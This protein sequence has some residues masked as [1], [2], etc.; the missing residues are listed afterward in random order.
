M[1]RRV[2]SLPVRMTRH[3]A[4]R[5]LLDLTQRLGEKQS[6]EDSLGAVTDAALLLVL[7][8]HS[9]VRLLDT[10]RD[11]FLSSARS[12]VGKEHA[13]VELR[14]GEGVIGWVLDH[15]EGLA[16][17]DTRGDDRF[18]EVEAQRF[19]IR[20]IVAEPLWSSGDVIG[21][22]S[23]SSARTSAFTHEDRLL[24]RL[25][26]NC[27]IPPIERARLHR[28]AI[29]DDL[30]LA[31]NARHLV[32]CLKEEMQRARHAS[33]PLSFLLMDL[34]H[35]KNV[36]DM[37]GHAVGDAV[38]RMF[39]DR[40][41]SLVRRTDILVRRG[42]EEFALLM[43]ATNERDAWMIADRIRETLATVPIEAQG[44]TLA[45]TVSI[46]VATWDGKEAGP[47]LEKRADLAM[48]DAKARG[49]NRV[50]VAK[51]TKPSRAHAGRAGDAR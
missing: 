29:V 18:V 8:D 34:D 24:V 9:S 3:D 46:G 31:Y 10:T 12:G 27:S 51:E 6:L 16:I 48:Y 39:A 21:V 42:G 5:V 26:A 41:R 37:H 23:V 1:T 7:A 40:V 47:S 4:I 13:P 44:A 11:S 19:V 14:R 2:V 35:F 17:D 30:T 25:L 38:L 45:Q 15:R 20:S 28:L 36:N 49:R 22:L 32:P 43:P 50:A 33:S